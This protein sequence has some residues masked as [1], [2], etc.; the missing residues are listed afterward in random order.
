MFGCPD[1]KLV[2]CFALTNS[3]A[4]ITLKSVNNTRAEDFW[5]AHIQNK[6]VWQ[7]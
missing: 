4:A 5:E 6:I 2:F 3:I 1:V 7:L